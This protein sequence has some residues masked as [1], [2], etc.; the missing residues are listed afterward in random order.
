[1]KRNN[2][3][4]CFLVVALFCTKRFLFAPIHLQAA[5]RGSVE[6]DSS[7]MRTTVLFVHA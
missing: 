1:M 4:F 2:E 6:Q 3:D 5:Q 7:A